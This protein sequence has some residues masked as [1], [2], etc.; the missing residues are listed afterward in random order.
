MTSEQT[1]INTIP[2]RQSTMGGTITAVGDS[3]TAGFGVAADDA[4]PALLGRKLREAGYD[5]RVINSGVNGEKSAE[6]LGRLDSILSQRPDI[7]ILQTGTN[8]GLRGFSP[9]EMKRNIQ[10]IV[11]ALVEHG[12]TVVLAGMQNLKKRKGDYDELFAQVYTEVALEEGLIL[13]PLFLAGVMGDLR[14]NRADGIHPTAEG[15]RKVTETVFPHVVEA[16]ARRHGVR[17]CKW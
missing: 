13:V 2:V 5:Y 17:L 4:Y 15:Y 6:V 10:A 8:D 11:R 14:V 7:V 16:I 3:L 12:V 9:A 1:D